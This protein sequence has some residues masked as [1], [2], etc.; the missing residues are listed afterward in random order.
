M[1]MAKLERM[2]LLHYMFTIQCTEIQLQS[3]QCL[4]YS[5]LFTN[6]YYK[7]SL[8]DTYMLYNTPAR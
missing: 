3:H 1:M 7:S 5:E 2:C 6:P 4:S 8:Q